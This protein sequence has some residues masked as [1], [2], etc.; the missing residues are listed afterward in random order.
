MELTTLSLGQHAYYTY[1]VGKEPRA[2]Q[3]DPDKQNFA[4]G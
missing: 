1:K 4:P 2:T 3:T